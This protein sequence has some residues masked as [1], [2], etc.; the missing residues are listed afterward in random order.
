MNIL[1]QYQKDEIKK[2]YKMRIFIT[3]LWAAFF[4]L[5]LS[6]IFLVPVYII[7]A[8]KL[9]EIS[10]QENINSKASKEQTDVLNVPS[11]VDRKA[12]LVIQNA[13]S[14]SKASRVIKII[15]ARNYGV[16]VNKIS[17]EEEAKKNKNGMSCYKVAILGYA[18]DRESLI[19][20]EKT[21]SQIDFVKNTSVPVGNF[22][23]DKDISFTMTINIIDE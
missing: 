14:V 13:D 20:F 2:G 12:E 19:S 4:A 23:K 22:A 6:S 3:S 9:H 17:Y 21:I 1:P 11:M 7:A 5:I 18:P 8:S 10:E 16:A 15:N